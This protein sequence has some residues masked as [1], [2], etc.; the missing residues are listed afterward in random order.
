MLKM[1]KKFL[2]LDTE[3]TIRA[4][5]NPFTVGNKLC[6]TGYKVVGGGVV[7][8]I[9]HVTDGHCLDQIQREIDAA[10]YLVAF[11][12]KFDC[13]W[14]ENIG[15]DLS[16]IRI[17]DCQYAEF[18]FSKQQTR[19][20][21]LDGAAEHYGIEKKLDIVKEYWEK[22]IDTIDI[23]PEIVIQYLCRDVEITEQVFIKQYELFQTTERSK[24][25]LFQLHMEDQVCLREMERNGILYDTK[26]SLGLGED[27]K[28]KIEN[29]ELELRKGYEGVPLNFDSVDHMSAYLYGG[30]IAVDTRIPIGVYKTGVKTGQPRYKIVTHEY[31]LPQL[32]KPLPKSELKK[33]GLWAT[34]EKTIKQLAS[35]GTAEVKKRIGLLDERSKLEK[36]RGTYFT[37]FPKKIDEMAWSDN[38]IHSSLNQ[39]VAITGRLSSTSPNQQNI[40]PECKQLCISRYDS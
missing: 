25:R 24:W 35:K 4:K 19:Y 1:P 31:I 21:S 2:I 12:A 6:Y 13:H 28:G 33:D 18:L 32:V 39:C 34:D 22:N 15:V 7:T 30:T 27:A 23:P 26:H 3:T 40:P 36:L 14:L 11:N 10:D 38:Y 16:K 29:I 20:P 37:G 5:G 17:F 9:S 8:T